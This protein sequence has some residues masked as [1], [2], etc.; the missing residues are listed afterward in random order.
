[1]PYRETSNLRL[2]A[3]L[4]LAWALLPSIG[5][6]SYYTDGKLTSGNSYSGTNYQHILVEQLQGSGSFSGG[7]NSNYW[8]NSGR[9]PSISSGHSDSASLSSFGNSLSS[10]GSSSSGSASI[11]LSESGR[12]PSG[13]PGSNWYWSSTGGSC[14]EL[15]KTR[16]RIDRRFII[17]GKVLRTRD[18]RECETECDRETLCLGFNYRFKRQGYEQYRDN[19]EL[20]TQGASNSHDFTRDE[21][22]DF[23]AKSRS[24]RNCYYSGGESGGSGGSWGGG[25]GGWG[26][27]GL[28][29]GLTD[30]RNECF[31]LVVTE[32]AL[33]GRVVRDSFTVADIQECEREC[34]R[35]RRYMCKSFSFR[36]YRGSMKNKNCF[37]SDQEHR[38]LSSYNLVKERES[39]F[40]ERRLYDRECAVDELEYED[41]YP[42]GEGKAVVTGI[43]CYRDHC[44]ED[45]KAGYFFCETDHTGAWDY[46]CRPRARCGY[47][48][49]YPI[50]WCYVGRVGH[51]QWRP[52]NDKG[53]E[54]DYLHEDPH[55]E[56]DQ[57]LTTQM[58]MT[59]PYIEVVDL[60]N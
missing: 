41:Q 2:G 35:S 5:L 13:R 33:E 56:A 32:S 4:A 44:R 22:F 10:F 54:R 18:R 29:S 42:P 49:D 58:P 16:E 37:L 52:C 15:A 27:G 39:D 47:S 36:Y 19:C 34:A 20:S 25:S 21:D 30:S 7:S 31:R 60:N 51:N 17:R 8:S 40:Y 28:S 23:Y 1:M 50:P 11:S 6:C 48:E 55:P 57:N 43:R 38:D 59:T 3:V 53:R 12:R 24:G 46:C 45:R 9:R 26:G 14:Y